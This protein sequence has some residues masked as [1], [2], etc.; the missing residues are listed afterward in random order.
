MDGLGPIPYPETFAQV[1]PKSR[2]AAEGS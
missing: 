1:L 2:S